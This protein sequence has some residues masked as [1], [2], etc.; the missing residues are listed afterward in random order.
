MARRIEDIAAAFDQLKQRYG[1]RD[2]RVCEPLGD[3]FRC[4]PLGGSQESLVD[5]PR[6]EQTVELLGGLL[7]GFASQLSRTCRSGGLVHPGDEPVDRRA[8]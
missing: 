6:V 5:E 8:S 3:P 7:G 4:D 2:A 1:S